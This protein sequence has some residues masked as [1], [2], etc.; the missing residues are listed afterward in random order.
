MVTELRLGVRL[1]SPPYC[2]FEIAEIMKQCFHESP[3]Q[4]PKFDKLRIS[5]TQI[6]SALRKAP[7]KA[8]ENANDNSNTSVVYS[9]FAMKEQYML[10]RQKHKTLHSILHPVEE[11]KED[12]KA[13]TTSYKE[14][15]GDSRNSMESNTREEHLSYASLLN[16]APLALNDSANIDIGRHLE[17]LELI[18]NTRETYIKHENT[19]TKYMTYSFEHI[20][21]EF[22]VKRPLLSSVSFNPIYLLE[23]YSKG[24]HQP[25]DVSL[26]TID[27]TVH[28]R[29]T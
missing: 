2:P 15:I 22:D 5:L 20:S 11:D 4:R 12:L 24:S 10:V 29:S 8:L 18:P 23:S 26:A 27:T 16:T 7:N 25:F 17:S 3:D 19:C 6:T 28:P 9:D 14:S 1:P 21:K 13:Q